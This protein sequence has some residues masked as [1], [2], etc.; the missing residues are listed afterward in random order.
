[1][2]KLL[3]ILLLAALLPHRG[4]TQQPTLPPDIQAKKEIGAA[5][6][7]VGHAIETKD[8]AALE[9]LWSPQMLVNSPANRVLNREEVFQAI[10]E[11]KLEYPS[12]KTEI[13]SFQIIGD[14]GIMMGH[15]LFIEPAGLPH[16]GKQRQR[17]FTNVWQHTN[18]TWIQIARQATELDLE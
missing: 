16:A 17:R 1:V 3:A 6:A 10:R 2:K 18:G 8:T 14:I 11:G 13:E 9:K 4:P 12:I 7:A 15:Q 5:S